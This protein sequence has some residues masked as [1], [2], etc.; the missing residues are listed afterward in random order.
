[1]TQPEFEILAK[2]TGATVHFTKFPIAVFQG[3]RFTVTMEVMN[4]ERETAL[5]VAHRL[6]EAATC[7]DVELPVHTEDHGN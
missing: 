4:L 5:E 1:M 6:N 7:A 2:H 3:K